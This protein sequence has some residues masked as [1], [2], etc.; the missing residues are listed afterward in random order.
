MTVSAMDRHA[1]AVTFDAYNTLFDFTSGA[2]AQL[3][4][5][6]PSA[7]EEQIAGVWDSMNRTF[8]VAYSK[9]AGTRRT[10][11]DAFI[12]LSDF[13]HIAVSGAMEAMGIEADVAAL[14]DAWNHFISA[15]PLYDDA[16]P[17]VQWALEHHPTGIVSDIDTWMLERNVRHT[18]LPFEHYVTSEEDAS[19]KSMLDCTMFHAMAGKL[20][21]PVEGIIHVGDSAA[22]I[23][24]A[25]RAGA[26]AVWLDRNGHALPE[27]VPTP[28]ETITTLADLPAAIVRLTEER[29]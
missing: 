24:G 25:H 16:L 14:V 5:M 23:L 27:G 17:A 18:A 8:A 1:V 2:E 6:L 7:T 29:A 3:R 26:R 4:T 28:D 19:Y 12:T 13:H 15:A 9:L 10:D 11:Y 21:C 22:D 20:G